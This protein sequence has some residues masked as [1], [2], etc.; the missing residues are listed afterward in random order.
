M[1]LFL[2]MLESGGHLGFN[3]FLHVKLCNKKGRVRNNFCE[4]ETKFHVKQIFLHVFYL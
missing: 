1:P 2:K 4:H 3:K